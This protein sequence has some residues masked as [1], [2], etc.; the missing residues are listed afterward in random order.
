MMYRIEGPAQT[1][2][3]HRHDCQKWSP[4]SRVTNLTSRK[5]CDN[6]AIFFKPEKAKKAGGKIVGHGNF[7][8]THLP[9]MISSMLRPGDVVMEGNLIRP[10][11][12]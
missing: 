3:S 1:E 9:P 2:F 5:A 8:L 7:F 10:Q 6:T 4:T 12:V 11:T